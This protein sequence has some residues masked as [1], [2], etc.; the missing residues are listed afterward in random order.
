MKLYVFAL[1]HRAIAARLCLIVLSTCL[2][3]PAL[4]EENDTAARCENNRARLNELK[5]ED[6][7]IEL[8]DPFKAKTI[9]NDIVAL[10]FL[11]T[12]EKLDDDDIKKVRGMASNYNF[13]LLQCL[14]ISQEQCGI[15]LNDHLNKMN[16]DNGTNLQ[17]H[18]A[19]LEQMH[20]FE[21][22]LI[23]LGCDNATFD[24]EGDWNSNWGT[25]HLSG[26]STIEGTYDYQGGR[27]YGQLDGY[28]LTGKWSQTAAGQKCKSPELGSYYWGKVR[29]SFDKGGKSF[30]GDWSYCEADVG[31][32]DWRGS[33]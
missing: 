20:P 7:A 33:R 3:L 6:K 2:G 8:L 13:S 17:R 30:T 29:L 5:A 10:Q 27:I 23:A 21:V 24:I 31:G 12:R 16:L 19:L 9:S 15:D 22:N 28:V 4:A 18:A 1:E 14:T 26:L 11:V 32:G 25:M